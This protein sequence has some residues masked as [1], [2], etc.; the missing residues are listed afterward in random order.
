MA[1]DL[2]GHPCACILGERRGGWRYSGLCGTYLPCFVLA[3]GFMLLELEYDPDGYWPAG[4]HVHVQLSESE[5]GAGD[6]TTPW[7]NDFTN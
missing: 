2:P 3:D 1:S 5:P 4:A 6:Q 7:F